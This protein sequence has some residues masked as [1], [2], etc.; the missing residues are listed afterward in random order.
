MSLD[1]QL[2][3]L[4]DRRR[5]RRWFVRV[6]LV[7]FIIGF[8]ALIAF[9]LSSDAA[10]HRVLS[11]WPICLAWAGVVGVHV[12]SYLESASKADVSAVNASANAKGNGNG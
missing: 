10:L 4:A 1:D 3:D 11:I 12:W 6:Q 5:E 8:P 9:A 7:V 2:S